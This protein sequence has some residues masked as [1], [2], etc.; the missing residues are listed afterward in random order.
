MREFSRP[1]SQGERI[2]GIFATVAL[3]ILFGALSLFLASRSAWLAT[4]VCGALTAL[5]LFMLYRAAFGIGRRLNHNET[6]A[7]AWL[8]TALGLCGLAMVFLI[9][10]STTHRLMVLG[11]AITFLSA[12]LAGV[13]SGGHDA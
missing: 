11:G 10:G 1:P 7:V 9:D 13:R 4:A 5:A 12:G 2:V 8:F 6:R 3:A